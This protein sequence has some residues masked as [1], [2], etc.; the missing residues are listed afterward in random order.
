M[1]T[2]LVKLT[3]PASLPIWLFSIVILLAAAL[4]VPR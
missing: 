2:I 3:D 4:A 1:K